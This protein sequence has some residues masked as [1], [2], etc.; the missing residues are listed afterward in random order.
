MITYPL[1]TT[2]QSPYYSEKNLCTKFDVSSIKE[3]YFSDVIEG[4]LLK[5]GRF[6]PIYRNVTSSEGLIGLIEM[7]FGRICKY[8]RFDGKKVTYYD[9]IW[10]EIDPKL[11]VMRVTMSESPSGFSVYEKDSTIK[12]QQKLV[13][14]VKID[15]GCIFSEVNE[16][17]SLFKIYKYLTA[18]IEDPY[19]RQVLPFEKEIE[20]FV[21]N[22]KEKLL[23]N[24]IE[25]IKLAYR[26]QKLF[27]RNLIQK[28]FIKFRTKKVDDGR[29]LNISYSDD[30]GGNVKASSGGSFLN[31]KANQEFDLQDSSVYFD[32]KE[33]IY[34][35][36]ELSSI[37]V[38]WVN[39]S[40]LDDD[41]FDTI[42]IRY[43]AYKN[44]YV[45]HFLRYNV[46]E[47]IYDYVLPKF[48]EYKRKPL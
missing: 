23:I 17:Q 32:T 21:T 22:M 35:D 47:E 15:Y 10:I 34:N 19:Y 30:V 43:S 44:F 8:T 31:G 3:L 38:S 20:E 12:T 16:K 29:I 48:N 4:K 26:I 18:H 9:F 27:E 45:T 37:T 5:D 46:R 13:N 42:D 2:E 41:R 28:D 24:D 11:Q 40:T 39:K 33:S 6:E 7:A 36:R 1:L 14:K 25:D